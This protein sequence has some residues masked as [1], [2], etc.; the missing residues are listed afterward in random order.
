MNFRALFVAYPVIDLAGSN[1][2][3]NICAVLLNK[4]G[5][6]GTDIS[7]PTYSTLAFPGVLWTGLYVASVNSFPMT[8][9]AKS[10]AE[11]ISA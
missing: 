8:A 9:T 2:V 1:Y 3:G 7:D 10:T 11:T 4:V 6:S 5:V